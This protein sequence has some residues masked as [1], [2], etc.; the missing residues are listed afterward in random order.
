MTPTNSLSIAWI[1][2]ETEYWYG[3]SNY[4]SSKNATYVCNES[5]YEDSADQINKAMCVMCDCCQ[6]TTTDVCFDY[7]FIYLALL[8][9]LVASVIAYRVVKKRTRKQ[10]S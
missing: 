9:I 8:A 1:G 5:S 10:Q 2:S 4:L 6:Q 3:G 7:F